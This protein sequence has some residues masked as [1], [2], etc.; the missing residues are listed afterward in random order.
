VGSLRAFL[1]LAFKPL[2]GAWNLLGVGLPGLAVAILWALRNGV[3]AATIGLVTLTSTYRFLRDR[4]EPDEVVFELGEWLSDD[5]A[6]HYP[7]PSVQ[8]EIARLQRRW[9]EAGGDLTKF[10]ARAEGENDR[11]YLR[12][13]RSRLRE[14]E[15][16]SNGDLERP[17]ERATG[18]DPR[19]H[20]QP[21]RRPTEHRKP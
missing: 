15:R 11:E 16:P 18:V 3:W 1:A 17:P 9:E 6:G 21:L 14:L 19:G 10:T 4:A 5:E 7:V 13:I 2:R 20:L 8:D 12:S